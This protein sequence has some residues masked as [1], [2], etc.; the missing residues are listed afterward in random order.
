MAARATP[1]WSPWVV[2]HLVT[3]DP[4]FVIDNSLSASGDPVILIAT[5]Q[6]TVELTRPNLHTGGTA[7]VGRS[8]LVI[9]NANQIGPGPLNVASGATLRITG[10]TTF[11]NTIDLHDTFAFGESNIE[12]MAGVSADF[13]GNMSTAAAPQGTFTKRGPGR[14]VF[15]PSVAWSPLGNENTWGLRLEEG[16]TVLQQLP[17]YDPGLGLWQTGP[18]VLRGSPFF[19]PATLTVTGATV[20]NAA[21]PDNAGF[22][23]LHVE[24]GSSTRVAVDLGADLR[25]AGV[26]NRNEVFGRLEKIGPGTLWFGGD[27]SGG[28][29]DGSHYTGRGD[30]D[31]RG[32]TVRFGNL[33]GTDNLARA[34]PDDVVL[35]LEDQTVMIKEQDQSGQVHSLYI[36]DVSGGGS[37]DVILFGGFSPLGD[38]SLNVDLDS[39]GRFSIAGDL[40]KL[41]NAPLRFSANPAPASKSIRVRAWLS[42][43]ERWKPMVRASI[44]SPTRLPAHHSMW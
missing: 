20:V 22:R 33:P 29:A 39:L 16:D 24:G 5:D 6:A 25:L 17:E 30:L 38:G 31:I 18:L 9:S 21:N 11:A 44:R 14:L 10:T 3:Q 12:V 2:D 42:P 28:N 41:G 1:A 23:V 37:A 36:N 8:T 34:F 26:G 35:R 32:G 7:V 13:K 15:D 27:S 40:R 19:G 43:M 4:T